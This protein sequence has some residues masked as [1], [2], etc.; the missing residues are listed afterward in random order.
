[1]KKYNFMLLIFTLLLYSCTSINYSVDS[2][3]Y[4]ATGKNSRVRFIVL[5]YTATNDEIGLKTLTT[6]QVSAHYLV[7]SKDSDPVYNL[8]PENERAWHAGFSGFR[9]RNNIN[10]SSIGI[11]ITNIGVDNYADETKEYGFFIPYDKYVPYSEGQIK[12]IAHLL[13]DIL[14]RYKID[15]T[16][17]VGHSDIAP[18]RKI[19]PGAKFPWKRLYEEYGIG[20]WYNEKDKEFYMNERLYSATPISQIKSEFR[21][22]GYDINSTNE[23]DEESRRV[24]YAFQMHFNPQNATGYLDLETFA[25]LKALNKKYR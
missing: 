22:Y 8:V 15:P 23:W 5:H 18:L 4:K 14:K 16:N 19:D 17:I 25:I 6:Q 9:G 12:K 2:K 13:K 21:R 20:A 10:D 7:T 1:M 3:S 11:E 24:V